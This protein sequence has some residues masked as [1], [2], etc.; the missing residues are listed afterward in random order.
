MQIVK[1]K[2]TNTYTQLN[3]LA[4]LTMKVFFVSLYILKLK[5]EEKENK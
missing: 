3:F 5:E 1:V 4:S 2:I